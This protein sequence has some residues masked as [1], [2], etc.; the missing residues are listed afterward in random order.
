MPYGCLVKIWGASLPINHPAVVAATRSGKRKTAKHAPGAPLDFIRKV[1]L[2]ACNDQRHMAKKIVLCVVF[3][4]G[5]FFPY[6][7]RFS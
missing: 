4:K 6:V 7:Y 5:V 2:A 1:E 3:I